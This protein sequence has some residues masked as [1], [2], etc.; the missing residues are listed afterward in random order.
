M[1][2]RMRGRWVGRGL[3]AVAALSAV[4]S[5]LPANAAPPPCAGDCNGDGAVAVNELVLGVNIALGTTALATCPPFDRDDNDTVS[6]NELIGAVQNALAG[7]STNET[8]NY[9]VRGKVLQAGAGGGGVSAAGGAEITASIDRNGNGRIDDGESSTA[10]ADSDGNY[11]LDL[12]VTE[13]ARVVVGFGTTDSAPLFRAL[14]AAPGGDLVLNVTLRTAEELECAES[15]CEIQG[16]RLSIEGLP[17]GVT[18]SAQ[19]FNPVTQADAFPGDFADR[20]GNLLL[21]GVFA[22]VELTNEAGDPVRDLTA[23]ATLRMQVPRETWSI[24]TDVT[25]GN[26][27]IDVPLYA[28]DEAL[29]TWVRD[30]AAVLENDASAVIPEGSLASIRDGSYSGGVVARGEVDHFSYWNVDW[31]IDS[32]ACLTGRLLTADGEPAAGAM[33]TVRGVTYTGTSTTTTNA[34]GRFC[35]D[36]LR[37]EAAGEDVDQDGVTGETQRIAVRVVHRGRVYDAGENAVSTQAAT[38]DAGCSSIGEVALTPDRELTPTICRFTAVV[39]GRDGQPVPGAVVIAADDT[40]DA[41]LA[42]E[43]C[44]ATPEGY[45]LSVGSTDEAGEVSLTAVV[46][47]G[48]FT[49]AL[50]STQDAE[51]TLQRWGETLFT[52][53]PTQPLPI[54][55]TDGYRLVTLS[56]EFAPPRTIRWTPATYPVTSLDVS[57]ASDAKWFVTATESGF[58]SPVTYG[59]TPPGAL[60]V[61]PFNN[62]TPPALASGDLISVLLSAPGA[63]GYP[64]L[65]QGSTFVP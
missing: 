59:A 50:S 62:A 23:P 42:F 51:S 46:I 41:D 30:G 15:R 17:S 44:S 57:G 16:Q 31:P 54:P 33:V 45:C 61:F 19:V 56:V 21:S 24:I 63:D 10:S 47:D 32:H 58:M 20:D 26:G 12:A 3:G 36:V 27:R 55:L 34:D 29:G 2:S 64:V 39:R 5:A 65:G 52:G 25:P 18:G 4:L 53:C 35:V 37:S 9:V 6:V 40:V 22:S 7:C 38:C 13:G 28:F 60:Q 14:D 1:E 49:I 11:A 8:P 48:L 43:L